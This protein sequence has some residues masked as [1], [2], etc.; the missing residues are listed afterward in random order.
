MIRAV[1][2]AG[3]VI[4]STSTLALAQQLDG[5]EIGL[6]LQRFSDISETNTS[7]YGG[8]E[9]AMSP[10]VGFG[11]DASFTTN[12]EN[13]ENV[14]SLTLHGIYNGG[15][16][17]SSFGLFYSIDSVDDDDASLF[18]AEAAFAF[19][20]G[21]VDSYIGAGE[22]DDTNND[23]G[24]I[25]VD[26]DY[27]LGNGFGVGAGFESY[28]LSSSDGDATIRTLEIGGSYR[29]A[30]EVIV[31]GRLG[32]L[33]R[34]IDGGADDDDTYLMIGAEVGFGRNGGLTFGPR[35]ILKDVPVIF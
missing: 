4:G 18:G 34:D 21:R 7:Y 6:E 8:V 28:N 13:S 19:G 30:P 27:E 22:L 25:G 9:V 20:R 3:V 1:L 14:S 2:Y 16:S 10:I 11:A 29:V 33:N 15:P 35:S 12:S 31:F 17:G 32:N 24:F 23:I 5:A 26:L